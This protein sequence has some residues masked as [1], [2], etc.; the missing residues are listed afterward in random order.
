MFQKAIIYSLFECSKV[1][2]VAKTAKSIIKE[3]NVG[4]KV[5]ILMPLGLTPHFTVATGG[6]RDN[7]SLIVFIPFSF[8]CLVMGHQVHTT[9]LLLVLYMYYIQYVFVNNIY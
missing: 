2:T 8:F 3:G 6:F 1:N 9:L 5:C 7:S 4:N